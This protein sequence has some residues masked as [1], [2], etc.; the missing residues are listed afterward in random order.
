MESLRNIF[1]TVRITQIGTEGTSLDGRL[2]NPTNA[3]KKQDK[4]KQLV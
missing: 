1:S 3:S 4:Q 2:T